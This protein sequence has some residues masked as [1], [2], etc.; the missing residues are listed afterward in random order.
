MSKLVLVDVGNISLLSSMQYVWLKN[1][2]LFLYYN[3]FLSLLQYYL[4]TGGCKYGKACRF[5]HTREKTFSVPPLKT[6]MPSILELNFLGL[7]I[8]PVS[9]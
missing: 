1:D 2:I 4:R 3:Y 9:F 6:P 7:P 8:R 5:N